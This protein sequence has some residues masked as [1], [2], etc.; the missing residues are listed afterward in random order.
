MIVSM[1]LCQK[2]GFDLSTRSE[3]FHPHV[4][5]K[6][7]SSDLKTGAFSCLLHIFCYLCIDIRASSG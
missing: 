4:I 5:H 1:R 7:L 3:C 6:P 2:D